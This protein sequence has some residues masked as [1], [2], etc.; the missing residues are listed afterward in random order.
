MEKR[1]E[2]VTSQVKDLTIYKT[3]F[4]NEPALFN[5]FQAVDYIKELKN[6][7]NLDEAIAVGDAFY[8]QV[9]SLKEYINH[10]AYAIYEKYV[11]K[12]AETISANEDAFFN[13]VDKICNITKVER[14]SPKEATINKAIFYLTGKRHIN[15]A[16]LREM[17]DR[18]EPTTLSK[19]PYK[20]KDGKET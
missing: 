9:P 17:L 2:K 8:E 5:E 4:D 18:Q 14:Y 12:D 13:A 6:Q 20:T 1:N 19:E 10:Y 7:G 15:Y 11:A 3:K 16:K